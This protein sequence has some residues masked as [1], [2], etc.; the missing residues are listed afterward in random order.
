MIL[1]KQA[2]INLSNPARTDSEFSMYTF[3]ALKAL[4]GVIKY[5][6]QKCNIQMPTTNFSM[7]DK[8]NGVYKLQTGHSARIGNAYTTK[9][10]NCYNHFFNNRHTLFHFGMLIAG[11][12]TN[13]RLLKTKQEANDIIKATLK[14]IDENYIA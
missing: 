1:L 7:F 8:V 12:D 13:T 9:L 6:L 5:N 10:E 14:V 4:E 11:T 2:I 3:P